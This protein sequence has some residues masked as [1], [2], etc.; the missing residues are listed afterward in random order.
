MHKKINELGTSKL[1]PAQKIGTLKKAVALLK[2]L[3]AI[4]DKMDAQD[5][6]EHK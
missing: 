2:K 3:H 5:K 4:L 6:H 1:A